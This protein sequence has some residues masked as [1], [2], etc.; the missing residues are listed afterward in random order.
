MLLQS[1]S[2]S[3]LQECAESLEAGV[4]IVDDNSR[5]R[6]ELKSWL[7]PKT[8]RVHEADSAQAALEFLAKANLWPELIVLDIEMPGMDGVEFLQTIEGYPHRPALLIISG[9]DDVLI[10]SVATMIEAMGF[11]L[12]G[13][14]SKPCPKT[15]LDNAL[16]AYLANKTVQ[17]SLVEIVTPTVDHKALYEAV[18]SSTIRPYYQP[19]ITIENGRCVGVEALARW[20]DARGR[21]ISPVEFIPLAE[22][23]GLID[24]LT[25]D[26]V[27]QV[28][29]DLKFLRDAGHPMPVSINISPLTLR[30]REFTNQLISL[31]ENKTLDPDMISFEV[32]EGKL[33][34]NLCETLANTNRLR[35]KGFRF[36]ID[37]FGRGFSS[38]EKL[39]QFPFTELKIDRLFIE[40]SMQNEK[41]Y[42]LLEAFIEMGK[43]L[44]MTTVAEGVYNQE[45]LDL[46]N[47]LGCNQAQGNFIAMPMSTQ[48]L[49]GW[50]DRNNNKA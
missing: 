30:S 39:S 28:S 29:I 49:T 18:Y 22:Q 10:A 6:K 15:L 38:M 36:S 47:I 13:S 33:I 31:V 1:H 50:L 35:L 43:K 37:D 2:T 48:M 26:F 44:G 46:L 45:V 20:W 24:Q 42:R 17:T 23:F 8:R 25:A 11:K 32:T 40:S 5:S 12:I 7:F 4:L 9:A 41:S 27:D 3:L 34:E 21:P 19:K 16:R 14:F